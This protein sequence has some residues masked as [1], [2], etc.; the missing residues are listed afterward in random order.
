MSRLQH[1]FFQEKKL[2]RIQDIYVKKGFG[3]AGICRLFYI[4][5]SKEMAQVKSSILL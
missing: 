1:S 2:K 4:G 3:V 5:D